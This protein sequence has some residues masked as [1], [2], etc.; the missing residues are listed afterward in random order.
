MSVKFPAPQQ[1]PHDLPVVSD[2]YVGPEVAAWA[3]GRS[4]AALRLLSIPAALLL[5]LA[6]ALGLTVSTPEPAAAASRAVA[7]KAEYAKIKKGQSYAEV[8][9]TIGGK[10]KRVGGCLIGEYCDGT[11]GGIAKVRYDHYDWKS[12]GGATVSVSFVNAKVSEKSRWGEEVITKPEYTRIRK[13]MT[14]KQVKKIAGGQPY[15]RS[16]RT[17][18]WD[19]ERND[20]AVRIKFS[21]SGHVRSKSIVRF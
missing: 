16:G 20:R 13:G 14:Y 21:K 18:R 9:K 10:G 15:E 7:T 8:V 19:Y 1:G 6:L 3:A 4:G 2:A 11:D 12:I 17:Y 5:G